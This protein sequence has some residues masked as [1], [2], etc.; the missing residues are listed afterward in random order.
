MHSI[1][2]SY[3]ILKELDHEYILEGKYLYIDEK[4]MT[5]YMVSEL[6]DYPDLRNF[7]MKTKKIPEEKIAEILDKIIEVVAYL[8]EKGV[9]HRDLKPENILYNPQTDELKVID[10]ELARMQRYH[11]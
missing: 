7:M 3:Q 10:F 4:R 9:C 2:E 5:S 8:N 6:C 11:H 1:R